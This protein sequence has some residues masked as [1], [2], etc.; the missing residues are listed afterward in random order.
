MLGVVGEQRYVA[1]FLTQV[2]ITA[3]AQPGYVLNCQASSQSMASSFV[4]QRDAAG[5][6]PVACKCC[7]TACLL[8]T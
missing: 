3:V 7:D 4:L 5:S 1:G 8:A 2:R 6:Q